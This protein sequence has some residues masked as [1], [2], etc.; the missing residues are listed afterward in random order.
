MALFDEPEH[1]KEFEQYIDGIKKGVR[2]VSLGKVIPKIL[3]EL[4]YC[5]YIDRKVI[6]KLCER[7][8]HFG[9]W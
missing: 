4:N 7:L 6:F 8:G 5:K 3:H 9:C 2:G 1:Y